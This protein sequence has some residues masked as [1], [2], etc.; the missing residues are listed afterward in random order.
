MSFKGNSNIIEASSL[1]IFNGYQSHHQ[2]QFSAHTINRMFLPQTLIAAL[3]AAATVVAASPLEKRTDGQVSC[4]I[5]RF[6]GSPRRTNDP[7]SRFTCVQSQT[8]KSYLKEVLWLGGRCKQPL[9][10]FLIFICEIMT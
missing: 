6:D 7:S 4:V 3:M 2:Q 8:G 9:V 10:S 1:M 5:R